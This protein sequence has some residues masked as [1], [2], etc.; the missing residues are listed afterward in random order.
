MKRIIKLLIYYFAYTFGIGWMFYAGYMIANHTKELP[1]IS[2][3]GFFNVT[4]WG[5]VIST[6]A[7]GIH[8]I[9]WKYVKR[10][11][12]SPKFSN[13]TT[14]LPVS[15]I[16]ILGMS[17]WTN[18]LT[19]MSGLPDAMKQTFEL[20][21][22]HPLGVLSIVILSPVIEELFFRGAI[23]GY[24]LRT[25]G[26]PTL[27]I[28]IS[29]LIFGAIHGNPV[30]IPF[31]FITGLALGWVY[32]RTGSLIPGILMHFVNNGTSVLLF[33]LSDNPD[34]TMAEIFGTTGSA[35]LA[36]AGF[37]ITVLCIFMIKAKTA[38]QDRK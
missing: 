38:R 24:L 19:E 35:C 25:W 37:I 15:V 12:L 34:I 7:I 11:E 1:G 36:F 29:S 14:I 10:N 20:A 2:D 26:K 21:M 13:A 4:M 5:Q 27:A 6:L 32:Y 16:L 33:H 28:V 8:I 17:L 31:A 3:P 22:Y 9:V 18:Y 23:Q 30:Q